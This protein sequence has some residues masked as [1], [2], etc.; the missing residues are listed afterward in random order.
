MRDAWMQH[1]LRCRNGAGVISCLL[2]AVARS[3]VFFCSALPSA[4]GKQ[5]RPAQRSPAT[6][7]KAHHTGMCCPSAHSHGLCH[8]G[9]TQV[10]FHSASVANELFA[11]SWAK[12]DW[13]TARQLADVNES[14]EV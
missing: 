11:G 3:D 13:I 5:S 1:V 14:S 10:W 6:P 7:A 8:G 4:K 9:A 2:C 12:L